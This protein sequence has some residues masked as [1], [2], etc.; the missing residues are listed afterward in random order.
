MKAKIKKLYGS[1]KSSLLLGYLLLVSSYL[2]GV[3]RI[4]LYSDDFPAIIE[5][6]STALNLVSDTRPIWGLGM[7]LFF[8][9]AKFTGLYIIPKVV[10]FVGLI[11]L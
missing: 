8:S 3:L 1:E 5:T 7:F 9:L 4:S 2:P 10:G 11:L 6:P